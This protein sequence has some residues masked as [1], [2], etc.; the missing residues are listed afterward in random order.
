MP[1]RKKSQDPGPSLV[2]MPA[3]ELIDGVP[4]PVLEKRLAEIR[5]C[6]QTQGDANTAH[7]SAWKALEEAGVA[8]NQGWKWG[9]KLERME[10]T[11]RA[12][13]LRSFDEA[14]RFLNLDAQLELA[15][16]A[17]AAGVGSELSENSGQFDSDDGHEPAEKQAGP[18][19]IDGEA[20]QIDS[21]DEPNSEWQPPAARDDDPA[22]SEGGRYYD[23]GRDAGLDG[24]GIDAKPY[25]AGSVPGGL[26]EAG[27][28]EG[29][30]LRTAP[31]PP[32]LGSVRPAFPEVAA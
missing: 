9:I 16:D 5:R 21:D 4:A 25:D 30:R 31:P 3:P 32:P 7:A 1:R 13:A 10:A 6:K 24:C 18:L 23:E 20:E 15:L 8:S 17:D 19:T 22:L 12:A 29:Q 2:G 28:R 27:W 11:K 14:R 26:W